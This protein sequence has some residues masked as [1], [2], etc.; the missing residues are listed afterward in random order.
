MGNVNNSVASLLPLLQQT[1]LGVM[2]VRRMCGGLTGLD[3]LAQLVGCVLEGDERVARNAAWVLTHC[4]DEDVMC[5]Q[6]FMDR[7]I[8]KVMRTENSSLRRLTLHLLGRLEYDAKNLRTDFLD[9]C[10]EH[11]QQLDEPPGVQSLCM[12]IACKLCRLYPELEEEYVCILQ[13]M[14]MDYYQAGV[15]G[16]RKKMLRH[17]L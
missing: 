9:F 8:D 14:E 12:K 5:L 2:D 17:A 11:M 13:N 16:L 6:G 4:P 10:L 7:L 15:K 3:D 1:R